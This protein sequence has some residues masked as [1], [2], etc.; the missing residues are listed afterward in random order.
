MYRYHKQLSRHFFE[1]AY[2]GFGMI[3]T[4]RRQLQYSRPLVRELTEAVG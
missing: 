2:A 3:D 4:A 1:L